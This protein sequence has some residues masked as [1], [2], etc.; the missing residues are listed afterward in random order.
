MPISAMKPTEGGH[1]QELALIPERD[2]AT[3]AREGHDAE[4]EQGLPQRPE[5]HVEQQKMTPSAM[6][7]TM[8]RRAEARCWFSNWPPQSSV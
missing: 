4:D 5:G 7:T 8:A 3:D 6:G 2:D 1:R